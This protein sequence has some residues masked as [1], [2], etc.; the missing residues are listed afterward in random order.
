MDLQHVDEQ[1]LFRNGADGITM[2]CGC[3]ARSSTCF[4]S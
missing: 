1:S 2:K 3:A 4:G